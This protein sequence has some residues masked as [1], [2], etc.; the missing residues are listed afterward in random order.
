MNGSP[1]QPMGSLSASASL[2]SGGGRGGA[3]RLP[4]RGVCVGVNG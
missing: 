3:G 2:P 4:K 1:G